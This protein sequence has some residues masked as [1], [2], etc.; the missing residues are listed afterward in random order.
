MKVPL[1]S[2]TLDDC[3]QIVLW[4]G[5]RGLGDHGHSER[6][7]KP[8]TFKLCCFCS[9]PTSLRRRRRVRN[10]VK[11]P[12]WLSLPSEVGHAE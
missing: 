2:P 6:V 9:S 1:P 7:N 11:I 10:E 3:L 5:Q 12:V 4:R 8:Q